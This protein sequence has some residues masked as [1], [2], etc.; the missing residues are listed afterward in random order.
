MSLLKKNRSP[1][2][3]AADKTRKVAE[4]V[5][6]TVSKKSK[7]SGSLAKGAAAAG[8]AAATAVGAAALW[9]ARSNGKADGMRLHV[10]SDGNGSWHLNQEGREDPIQVH[11]S[12]RA[13][14]SAARTYAR[15]HAPSALAIH[16][17]DGEIT[18]EHSYTDD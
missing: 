3:K 17:E 9:K 2:E 1:A 16:R 7:G 8:I 5:K 10:V 14:V 12:K 4:K 13:A 6:K 18:R 11:E 15:G